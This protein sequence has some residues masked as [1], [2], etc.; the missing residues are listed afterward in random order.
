[1][2]EKVETISGT[3]VRADFN[4]VEAVL[5]YTRAAHRL[6]LWQSERQLIERFF[7]D[8]TAPLLEAGCG[9]GRATLGLW[10]LGYTNLT[11]FDFAEE[12]VEQAR[13]L[14]ARRG[15]TAIRFLHADATRR[16]LRRQLFSPATPAVSIA[17][18]ASAATPPLRPD[19]GSARPSGDSA[20]SFTVTGLR[21]RAAV[22]SCA[23]IP[24]SAAAPAACPNL[25][26]A[27]ES[28]ASPR[29]AVQTRQPLVDVSPDASSSPTSALRAPASPLSSDL[30]PLASGLRPP[31]SGA[32]FLFNGLMQIPTRRARRT[33]LRNLAAVL[34][35]GAPFLFTTH[36]RDEPDELHLWRAEAK[37]WAEGKQDPRLHEYGDRYFEHEHGRTFMHLPTRDE[38]LRELAATGWVHEYDAMRSDLVRESRAVKDFSDNCRFW[39]VRRPP[40]P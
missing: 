6:G 25:A 26:A 23:T 15:A 12:L 31:F 3:I 38:M 9:A 10:E 21:S 29:P 8:K 34:A 40:A 4:A 27:H 22:R 28:G 33:A 18:L 39:L 13:D 5:H 1:M 16:T 14:A 24:A 17:P 11:A 30:S 2:A 36:D 32:L 20:P 19:S 7:P 35:P 37:R